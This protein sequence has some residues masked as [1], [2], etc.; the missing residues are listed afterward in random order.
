MSWV[1]NVVAAVGAFQI[2]KSNQELFNKQAALNR[3]KLK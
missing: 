1:G 3:E 2:G